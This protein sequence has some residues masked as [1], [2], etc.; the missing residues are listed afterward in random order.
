MK[1][2]VYFTKE[3][4]SEAVLKLYKRLGKEL[5]GEV[6]VKLHSGEPGNQ[7]FLKPEFFKNI[8]NEVKGT[9]V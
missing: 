5:K 9:V 2:V 8:I 6:A 3:L 1:P 7:N 4:T